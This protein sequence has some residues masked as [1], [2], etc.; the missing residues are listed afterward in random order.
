MNGFEDELRKRI[1]GVIPHIVLE[2]KGGFISSKD[3]IEKISSDSRISSTST[4]FSKEAILN[5][6]NI[7]TGALI[8]GTD[9]ISELSIIPD[10]LSIGSLSN[11]ENGNNIILGERL[12]LELGK[13]P[14]EFITS[15]GAD[16]QTQ[17][18]N[19]KK[20]CAHQHRLFI[21]RLSR[22]VERRRSCIEHS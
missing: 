19:K 1:L 14:N 21:H 6:E 17:S 7:T 8:K 4:F 9:G 12:A 20:T 2:K 18:K 10:F 13:F 3:T 22:L 16:E 15:L 11:L 5:S